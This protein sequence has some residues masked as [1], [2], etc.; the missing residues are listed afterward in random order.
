M[1]HYL[2]HLLADIAQ[3][4]A[5]VPYTPEDGW[6]LH[7]WLSPEE[8]EATAP[9]RQLEAWT[10]IQQEA[11]PSHE[12]LT[13]EQVTRTAGRIEEVAGC[14]QLALCAANSGAGAD[15]IRNGPAELSAGGHRE[16]VAHG[17]FQGLPA[18]TRT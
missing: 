13:D 1:H 16:A 4:T 5:A 9:R 2:T 18:R 8:E 17:L 10:G 12:Q 11:L 6:D 15:S 3:A 7:D 14:L